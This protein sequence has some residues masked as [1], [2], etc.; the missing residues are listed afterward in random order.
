MTAKERSVYFGHLWPEACFANEWEV[1]DD[2][3][4]RAVTAEC[5]RLV[6]GPQ[7]DSAGA[8]GSDEVT[9]L[10]TYLA[11]LADSASLEKSARWVTCQEDYKTFNRARQADWHE[12]ALYG[13]GKNKLD[14]NRF[15]GAASAAGG[16]LDTLD[17][18]EVQK[19]HLTFA[20]R[21]Q[22]RMRAEKGQKLASTNL[23]S[24]GLA[25]SDETQQGGHHVPEPEKPADTHAP[26]HRA[27]P[28]GAVPAW[29]EEEDGN[30]F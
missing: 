20:S 26:T 12:R 18:K 22:R 6:R 13:K 27:G 2:A 10:F 9:A 7:T 1:K 8:L 5:M 11:H 25:S 24:G 19:R 16:P 3:R 15:G 21:N 30:P 14:R 23:A 17:A 29:A 28:P 4:R